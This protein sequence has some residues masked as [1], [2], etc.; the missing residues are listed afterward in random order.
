ML[1]DATKYNPD[2]EYLR[3]LIARTG[4]SQR[5]CARRI[6]ISDR[7][8]RAHITRAGKLSPAPYPVQFALES[9]ADAMGRG[10]AT[11]DPPCGVD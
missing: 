8:M 4:L 6:G 9:L 3:E 2:P 11:P 7:N 1:P 10:D 5:E